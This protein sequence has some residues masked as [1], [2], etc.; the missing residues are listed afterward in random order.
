MGYGTKPRVADWG[1]G[2]SAGCTVGPTVR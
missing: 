1:S 2:M